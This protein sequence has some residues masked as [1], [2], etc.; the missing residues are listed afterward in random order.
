MIKFKPYSIEDDRLILAD[1]WEINLLA[2]L[3]EW[4]LDNILVG[5]ADEP[6]KPKPIVLIDCD[7]F[8]KW[9]GW[10]WDHETGKPIRQNP[11]PQTPNWLKITDIL[12]RL[13]NLIDSCPHVQFVIRTE[14]VERVRESMIMPTHGN[15]EFID[16]EDM[17]RRPNIILQ[18]VITTQ[19][20]AN[21][22]IPELLKCKELVGKIGVYCVPSE[23]IDISKF[24]RKTSYPEWAKDGGVY[25]CTHGI[26]GGKHCHSC[27]SIDAVTLN[28]DVDAWSSVIVHNCCA[29]GTLL[30]LEEN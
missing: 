11:R 29:S 24:V 12:T 19:A 25:N 23:E 14:H 20:E 21:D 10:V 28:C 2:D 16:A 9:N 13:F 17:C 5:R 18:A 26:A 8:I 15:A 22:R 30:K 3:A 4:G 6:S 7:P 1:R 27:H